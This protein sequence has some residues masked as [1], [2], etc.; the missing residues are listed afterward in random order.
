M[1]DDRTVNGE[2]DRETPQGAFNKAGETARQ[3]ASALRDQAADRARSYAADGKERASGALDQF[4]DLLEDAANQIDERLG[5]TYGGYAHDAAGQVHSL[6][7]YVRD[8]DVDDLVDDAREFVR[9]S[10]GV[11][12]GIAAAAGFVLARIVRSGIEEART[13]GTPPRDRD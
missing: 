5:R 6:A 11:A 10:P 9:K 2:P 3:Q 8:S 12:I 7:D 4:A 13:L 1:T